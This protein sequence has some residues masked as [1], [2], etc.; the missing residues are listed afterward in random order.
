MLMT[1]ADFSDSRFIRTGGGVS[2]EE[3]G[4]QPSDFTAALGYPYA[5]Q[6]A[7]AP[8]IFSVYYPN[9]QA[10][11]DCFVMRRSIITINGSQTC[12]TET[13][14]A[15][16]LEKYKKPGFQSVKRFRIPG[17]DRSS[18]PGGKYQLTNLSFN[19]DGTGMTSISVS[20]Q[21][22]GEWQLIR[23]VDSPPSPGEGPQ[24]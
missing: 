2:F 21:Q 3:R 20:Y 4:A 17:S 6:Y 15:S 14:R 13:F 22:A 12:I 23:L 7:D 5:K 1:P 18:I 8:S 16:D 10:F 9:W 24:T 19:D 11:A